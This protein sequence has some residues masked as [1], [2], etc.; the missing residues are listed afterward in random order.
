MV[1]FSIPLIPNTMF[2]WITNLSDRY[3][4]GYLMED[5][6]RHTG[7]YAAASKLP[8]FVT[9]VSTIFMQAW[10]LSAI[11]EYHT[12]DKSRFYTQVF[13]TFQM[14]VFVCTSLLMVLSKPVLSLL[15]SDSF[16]NPA[17]FVPFLLIGV[18]FQ[19][20]VNFFS[21]LYIAEKRSISNMVTTFVGAGTNIALNL[22]FIPVWGV[23]GAAF[24]TFFSFFV[25]FVIR[26]IDFRLVKGMEIR[27]GPVLLNTVIVVTQTF[28]KVLQPAYHEAI[29][30]A[31]CIL[32]LLC[33]G[34]PLIRVC[35]QFFGMVKQRLRH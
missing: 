18:A 26:Y 6:T 29:E 8:N 5:G 23:Q 31:M 1:R 2:W 32:L 16:D 7:I 24:A 12:K 3:L 4:I 9:L 10:Q 15:I 33:N 35:K 17:P 11:Q 14:V 30:I 21:T 19:C 13:T 20:L 25:V 27:F 28:V 34:L 22:L